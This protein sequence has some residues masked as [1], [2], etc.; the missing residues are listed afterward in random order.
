[1]EKEGREYIE[2]NDRVKHYSGLSPPKNKVRHRSGR[3]M[4][5]E[6]GGSA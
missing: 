2:K 4:R 3:L 1:M 6:K 5:N